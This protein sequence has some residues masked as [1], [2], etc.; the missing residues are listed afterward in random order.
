MCSKLFIDLLNA[1]KEIAADIK[2]P[3]E[4]VEQI[5][6]LIEETKNET[7]PKAEEDK[8]DF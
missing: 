7:S 5:D 1:L 2:A 3:Q 6:K 4:V 8:E